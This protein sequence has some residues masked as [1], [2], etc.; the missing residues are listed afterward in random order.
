MRMERVSWSRR[1]GVNIQYYAERAQSG[2]GARDDAAQCPTFKWM[3]A[4]AAEW[5]GSQ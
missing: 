3:F 4:P 1:I 5:Q 2:H